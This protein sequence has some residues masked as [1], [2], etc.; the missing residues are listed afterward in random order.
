MQEE[1]GFYRNEILGRKTGVRQKVWC[2]EDLGGKFKDI[3][4]DNSVRKI[5][6]VKM[7]WK[8]KKKKKKEK[9]ENYGLTMNQIRMWN[10]VKK[11]IECNRESI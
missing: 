10:D 5:K 2:C 1:R 6:V 8:A 9:R 7:P 3:I 11:L 4:K